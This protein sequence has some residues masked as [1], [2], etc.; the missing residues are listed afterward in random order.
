MEQ[1]KLI[2]PQQY[3]ENFIQNG[4]KKRCWQLGVYF[5]IFVQTKVE[6]PLELLDIAD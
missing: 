2:K 3:I 4:D 1:E 6:I 5:F